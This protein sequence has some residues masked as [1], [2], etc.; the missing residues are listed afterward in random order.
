MTSYNIYK[1]AKIMEEKH[2]HTLTVTER[3]RVCVTGVSEVNGVTSE[4]IV[5]TLTGGK[6]VQ[7]SGTM[8]KMSGFSKQ[9]TALSIEGNIAEI[10]YYGEKGGM[11]KRL[12]K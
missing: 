3:K 5:F 4:R 10:R 1:E 9:S 11:L 2:E 12:L 6:R 8:L 7:I